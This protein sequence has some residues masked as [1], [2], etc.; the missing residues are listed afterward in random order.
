MQV[1]NNFIIGL[2]VQLYLGLIHLS[3]DHPTPTESAI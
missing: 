1:R 3:T 2:A